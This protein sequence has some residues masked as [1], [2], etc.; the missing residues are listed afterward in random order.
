[1]ASDSDN[2]VEYLSPSFDPATLS[3]ARLRSLLLEHHIKYNPSA[4]KPQ[5]IELFN[6]ELKP[7]SRKILAARSRIRRT[8]KGI[9]D[10]PSSREGTVNGDDGDR[11]GS[12]LPPPVPDTPRRKPRKS[13]RQPSED[14]AI[15]ETTTR[16]GRTSSSKHPRP[17]DTE[18]SEVE[19]KR[20]TARKT[21]KSE[22]APVMNV[23]VSE[24]K[25]VRPPL[26]KSPFSDENP[27]QSGSSPLAPSDNRRRSAFAGMDRRK[28]HSRRRKT[29]G[30]TNDTRDRA[31]QHDGVIV[32]SSKT[33]EAPFAQFKQAKDED[34]ADSEVE[35]GEEF[36]PEE[37][38]ELS[39][40]RAANGGLDVLPARKTKRSRQSGGGSMLKSALWAVVTAL[41]SGYAL[42]LRREK[43]EVGYCGLGHTSDSIAG[44]QIPEW[45][46]ILQPECEPCPQHAICSENM[47][48]KCDPDFV[49]QPHPLSLGGLVPLPPSCEPDGEKAR[50]VK[51]VRD[52]AVEELRE[53]NAKSEC[54]TLTD[55]QGKIIRTPEIEEQELKEHVGRQRKKGMSDREFA[56]LWKGA[57][58]DMLGLDEVVQSSD[59]HRNLLASTSLAR[60][61][62]ACSVRRSLRLAVARYRIPIAFLMAITYAVFYARNRIIT[63]RNDTARVPALVS[64]TLDHLATQAALYNRGDTPE[65]WISIGQLRDDILRD[66]FSAKR[67]EKLWRRVRD[68]VEMNANVRASE[69]E[70]RAGD[71]SRVWEWIGSLRDDAFAEGRR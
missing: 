2:E 13:S 20:P 10:M 1:M 7:R 31:P 62:F 47:E 45:A 12:M 19:V 48:T 44:V 66:E 40:D 24:D 49:L 56:D 21:R 50:K 61:T 39:K 68:V 52:K 41:L 8:S 70:L 38:L 57:I 58:G 32:P 51:A 11:A 17:S 63:L 43:L 59:G 54:G 16:A 37:Q 69:R 14:P 18:T 30:V 23:E 64:T 36:T 15:Q 55:D 22:V 6:Q 33:F 53:R 26:E 25:L 27:F 4:K 5:L 42:W 28:S 67:R 34:E 29:E 46:S 9:T 60:I 65:S 3:V 35:A 71:V